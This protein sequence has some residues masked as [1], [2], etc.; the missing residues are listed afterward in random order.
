MSKDFGFGGEILYHILY[1]DGDE[2]DLE[3]HELHD[4]SQYTFEQPDADPSDKSDEED[5][6]ENECV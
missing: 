6:S 1:E 5:S 2:A 3:L 4:D